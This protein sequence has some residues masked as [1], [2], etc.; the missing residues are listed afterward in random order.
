MT[1]ADTGFGTSNATSVNDREGRAAGGRLSAGSNGASS[2]LQWQ[3]WGGQQAHA[4]ACVS[5][6]ALDEASAA[7]EAREK[8]PATASRKMH[9]RVFLAGISEPNTNSS[10]VKSPRRWIFLSPEILEPAISRRFAGRWQ[11]AHR[12]RWHNL[13]SPFDVE[14][15]QQFV[16]LAS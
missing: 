8:I 2:R 3:S 6:L 12:H 10:A 9:A 13:G 16:P 1:Q 15:G 11:Y 4:P 14:A 5:Q 7:N